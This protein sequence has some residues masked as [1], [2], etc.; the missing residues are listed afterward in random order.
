VLVGGLLGLLLLALLSVW[1]WQG[2]G[3]KPDPVVAKPPPAAMQLLP[4]AAVTLEA[5]QTKSIEVRVE[6][7]NCP[8]PIELWVEALPA[9][10][11]SRRITI[12]GDEATRTLELTATADADAGNCTVRVVAVAGDTRIES[13]LRLT[14]PLAKQITNSIKM[15]LVLIPAGKFQMGSPEGEAG[16]W[17]DEGPRHEV[18]I[19]QPFYMDKYAVTR[20]Q[21]RQFVEDEN[22]HGGKN[23]KTEAEKAKSA[24]TWKNPGFEQ[25]DEH[26]VAS[27]SWN[28]AVAFCEWLSQKEGKKYSLPTEAEWEYSCR[29]GTTTRYCFGNDE[30]L[31]NYAW[32]RENSESRTHPVGEKKANAWGLHDMH[33]NVWQWCQD[34]YAADYFDDSPRKDP[35]GP[36]RQGAHASHV[37]HGGSF[38]FEPPYCRSANR[39]SFHAG[40][41]SRPPPPPDVPAKDDHGFRVVRVR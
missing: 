14:I 29:A 24:C 41:F 3:K 15:E 2:V 28:D 36:E 39:G 30:A 20:G 11:R 5:G 10:V 18:E 37:E 16:R 26:P 9:G 31:S 35:R 40:E 22:Y 32:Y 17:K 27:V 6:R 21:F 1:L 12:P 38:D 34:Y 19:T 13:E 33:G 8:G 7:E 25:R 23:Y 4:L